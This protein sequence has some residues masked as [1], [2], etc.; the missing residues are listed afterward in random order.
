MNF[1][2]SIKLLRILL[3]ILGCELFLFVVNMSIEKKFEVKVDSE[4]CKGCGLCVE[5]CPKGVL[6]ISKKSNQNGYFP[7]QVINEK[8][9]VGCGNCFQICADYCIEIYKKI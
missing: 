2:K 5:V 8:N 1:L 9:C 7:A 4:R 6:E 3:R